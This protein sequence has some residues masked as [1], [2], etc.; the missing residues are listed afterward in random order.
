MSP[1]VELDAES[2]GTCVLFLVLSDLIL[3]S[4][5]DCRADLI[6][7]GGGRDNVLMGCPQQRMMSP[8]RF[9]T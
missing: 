9:S 6:G 8:T 7:T 1:K 3:D 4:G 5:V 2:I